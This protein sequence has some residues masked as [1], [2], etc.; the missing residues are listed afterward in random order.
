MSN[1]ISLTII[2]ESSENVKESDIPADLLPRIYTAASFPSLD[3]YR[4]CSR[5]YKFTRSVKERYGVITTNH[6][7]IMVCLGI[8]VRTV[9]A[10]NLARRACIHSIAS[11]SYYIINTGYVT[12]GLII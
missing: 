12:H 6:I 10:V 5:C 2:C 4:T 8:I 1:I 7:H 11:E 9:C 3:P